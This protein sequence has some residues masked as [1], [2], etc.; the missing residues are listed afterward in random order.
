MKKKV[1]IIGAGPAGMTAA[2]ELLNYTKENDG[3]TEGFEFT[4]FPHG[5]K[6]LNFGAMTDYT[7]S[8]NDVLKIENGEATVTRYGDS[9]QAVLLYEY[10]G[11]QYRIC[12]QSTDDLTPWGNPTLEE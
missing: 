2:N 3:K 9:M 12:S 10:N 8:S 6:I 7:D 11:K 4:G 5:V 1:I